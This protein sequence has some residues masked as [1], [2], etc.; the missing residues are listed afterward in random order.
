MWAQLSPLGK[1]NGGVGKQVYMVELA[2]LSFVRLV[3][4]AS[5]ESM[6]KL[7]INLS[8][9]LLTSPSLSLPLLQHG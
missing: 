6:D 4:Q 8:K 7:P 3:E 5:P 1:G 2:G 9:P